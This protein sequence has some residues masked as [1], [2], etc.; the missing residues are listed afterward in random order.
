MRID[1]LSGWGDQLDT[2]HGTYTRNMVKGPDVT[3]S[4]WLSPDEQERILS[5]AR[6]VRFFAMRDT[7]PDMTGAA[8]TSERP[9][10]HIRIQL[11]SLEHTVAWRQPDI[12][13]C[14][15]C[16]R[17]FL[18]VDSLEHILAAKPEYLSLPPRRVAHM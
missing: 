15:E 17:L 14:G 5:L 3:V 6:D 2:F 7:I 10:Q 9:R 1:Y 18:F 12:A 13:K 16:K 11:D 8:N 4:M